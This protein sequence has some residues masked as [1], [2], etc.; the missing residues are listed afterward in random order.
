[1]EKACFGVPKPC[2][3]LNRGPQVFF[4]SN[5]MPFFKKVCFGQRLTISI[6]MFHLY[7]TVFVII[8]QRPNAQRLIRIMLDIISDMQYCLLGI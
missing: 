5:D 1:M 8:Y 2:L 4:F 7:L 3:R 6:S